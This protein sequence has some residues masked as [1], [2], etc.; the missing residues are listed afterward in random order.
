M[1]MDGTTRR[2][3]HLP[4]ESG[5]SVLRAE[6]LQIALPTVLNG[7]K[8]TPTSKPDT[9]DTQLYLAQWIENRGESNEVEGVP[10]REVE[11]ANPLQEA[12]GEHPR[13]AT[14]AAGT[15]AETAANLDVTFDETARTALTVKLGSTVPQLR[16]LLSPVAAP[17]AL[18]GFERREPFESIGRLLL[19]VAAGETDGMEEGGSERLGF[20]G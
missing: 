12:G 13:V 18:L 2:H 1:T 16:G 10:V 5:S 11:P 14:S 3:L 6:R 15:D 7:R 9:L 20:T 17:F 8:Q 4:E 19:V